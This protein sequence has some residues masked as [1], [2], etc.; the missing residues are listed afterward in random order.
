MEPTW[1]DIFV[2]LL[3]RLIGLVTAD[4]ELFP[5]ADPPL[6]LPAALPEVTQASVG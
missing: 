3:H 5:G 4:V 2:P 6:S 1:L